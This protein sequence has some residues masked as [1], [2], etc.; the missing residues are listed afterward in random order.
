MST[1][2]VKLAIDGDTQAFSRLIKD[3]EATLYRVAKGILKSDHEC[4]D[5]IQEAILK[6]FKR[7]NTLKHPQFFKTWLVR[8]LINECYYIVKQNKKI[9]SIENINEIAY[10]KV[11]SFDVIEIDK[12][13]KQLI[14]EQQVIIILFYY[15]EFSIKEIMEMLNLREGTVKS[16]LHRA[17]LHLAK[18]LR[19]HF[20]EEEGEMYE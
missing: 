4:A 13:I 11:D 6:A 12:A 16:R 18:L 20:S 7:I 1:E 2:D 14:S 19:F 15:E 3:C 10:E 17:R 9:F 8:I 5:A